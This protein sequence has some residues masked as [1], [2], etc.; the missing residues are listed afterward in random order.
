MVICRWMVVLVGGLRKICSSQ[1]IL[2]L[3]VG[4]S[5]SLFT[6]QNTALTLLN[7]FGFEKGG[8]LMVGTLLV[9]GALGATNDLRE[10][11]LTQ[12]TG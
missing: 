3:G 12:L 1:E 10:T 11:D 6:V 5:G 8:V 4:I 9:V 7:M 2:S